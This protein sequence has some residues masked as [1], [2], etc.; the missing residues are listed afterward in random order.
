MS[1]L[2][3]YCLAQSPSMRPIRIIIAVALIASVLIV[4]IPSTKAALEAPSVEWSQTYNDLK[5]SSVIQ[6]SDGGYAI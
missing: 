6:T 1:S 3:N 2:K 5:A 4:S